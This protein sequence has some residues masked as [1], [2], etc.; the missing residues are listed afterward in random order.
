M[1]PHRS[2]LGWHRNC[3]DARPMADIFLFA[4]ECGANFVFQP[5]CQVHIEQVGT[6]S[7]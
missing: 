3:R 2:V 1:I 5:I 6:K 4:S 7:N